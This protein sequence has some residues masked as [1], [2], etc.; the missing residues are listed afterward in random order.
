MREAVRAMPVRAA[1]AIA[2]PARK[3]QD[4]DP[5]SDQK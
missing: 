2:A 4:D 3:P 1:P 5:L